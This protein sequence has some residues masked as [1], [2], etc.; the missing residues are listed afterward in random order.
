[1][2]VTTAVL[3]ID[4]RDS[5]RAPGATVDACLACGPGRRYPAGARRG[6]WAVRLRVG[7]GGL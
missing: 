3:G 6:L 4:N 2:T 1:M 7:Q 5:R